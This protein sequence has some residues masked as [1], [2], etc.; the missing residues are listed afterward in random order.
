MVS[1]GP[2]FTPG[3]APFGT[4]IMI[5]TIGDGSEKGLKNSGISSAALLYFCNEG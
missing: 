2:L 3:R 1:S 4:C 5:A